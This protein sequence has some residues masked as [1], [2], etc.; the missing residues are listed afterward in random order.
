M[1]FRKINYRL[2]RIRVYLEQRLLRINI[3]W[4]DLLGTVIIGLVILALGYNVFTAYNNGINNLRR[5]DEEQQKLDKLEAESE[6]LS[7]LEK[8]YQSLD[9]KRIYA[10][11]ILNLAEPD[12]TLYYIN[13]P[14]PQPKIENIEDYQE[15]VNINDNAF[16][17]KKLIF[18]I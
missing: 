5:I 13:R 16:W 10:R 15:S 18:N 2:K 11:E 3:D 8:Y 1:L 12:E 7:Q 17:W 14:E 9:F 6:E 4:Y